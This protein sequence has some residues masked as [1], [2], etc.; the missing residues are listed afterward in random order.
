MT[1][2]R[3]SGKDSTRDSPM[4]G[5]IGD[6]IRTTAGGVSATIARLTAQA[7][8]VDSNKQAATAMTEIAMEIVIGMIVAAAA[9]AGAVAEMAVTARI[10]RGSTAIRMES[11]TAP[12]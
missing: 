10:R 12:A 8:S 3:R 5:T 6:L 9:G 11:M 2:G 7:M 4:H 1:I